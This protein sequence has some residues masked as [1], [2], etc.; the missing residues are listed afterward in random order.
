MK[1]VTPSMVKVSD[2]A[3]SV[4]GDTLPAVLLTTW[5]QEELP[6]CP[7]PSAKS[8]SRATIALA[9]LPVDAPFPLVYVLYG[10]Y[11]TCKQRTVVGLVHIREA[12][13][14]FAPGFLRKIEPSQQMAKTTKQPLRQRGFVQHNIILLVYAVHRTRDNPRCFAQARYEQ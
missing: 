1:L 13:S 4:K 3:S 5:T 2:D 7:H 9:M 14:L 11:R 6:G 8:T 10:V 12:F